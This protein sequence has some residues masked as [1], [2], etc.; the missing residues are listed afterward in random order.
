M[1]LSDTAIEELAEQLRKTTTLILDT[2]LGMRGKDAEAIVKQVDH[3]FVLNLYRLKYRKEREEATI[4]VPDK[5]S[6]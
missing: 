3:V 5:E 2:Y 4:L 6:K 1:N